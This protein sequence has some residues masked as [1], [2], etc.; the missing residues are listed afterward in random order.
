MC[1]E[2][3]QCYP[4][5][6]LG[7][8]KL[9]ETSLS[10]VRGG[11]RIDERWGTPFPTEQAT[12]EVAMPDTF[13]AL[14]TCVS[15]IRGPREVSDPGSITIAHD[16]SA[17]T[18]LYGFAWSRLRIDG[19]SV[20]SLC[21]PSAKTFLLSS[22]VH[23]ITIR[24]VRLF[25][26]FGYPES[27]VIEQRIELGAG[28]ELRLILGMDREFK[29]ALEVFQFRKALYKG[30]AALGAV[31]I[32]FLVWYLQPFLLAL[33]TEIVIRFEL[34]ER[35][36]PTLYK[37]VSHRGTAATFAVIYYYVML[38]LL[39][40]V[41]APVVFGRTRTTPATSYVLVQTD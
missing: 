15:E 11:I 28:E 26:F 1:E 31:A 30:V 22:G 35:S 40:R 18:W 34:D 17:R 23:R 33:V 13:D 8:V 41:I 10:F 2:R 6:M 37:L 14:E 3:G 4:P 36:I 7:R 9:G 12:A 19:R 29:R 32:A 21:G 38:T 25:N 27:R 20:G 24:V 39:F 5:V 16:R